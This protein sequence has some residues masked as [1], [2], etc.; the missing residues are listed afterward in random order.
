MLDFRFHKRESGGL[1]LS[2]RDKTRHLVD[3]HPVDSGRRNF[4]IRC[5]QGASAALIPASLRDLAFSLDPHNASRGR[6]PPSSSLSQPDPARRHAPQ[7]E[8]GLDDVV[9]KIRRPDRA[10]LAEWGEGLIQSPQE[11]KAVERVVAPSFLGF[12]QRPQ[13]SRLV[14]PGPVEAHQ[15]K[16]ARQSS[17]GRDAFLEELRSDLG[18]FSKILTAEFQVTSINVGALSP[19]AVQSPLQARTRVRYELV[20]TGHDF[21]HEQ[22]VGYW[23][24]AWETD[25]SGD[26][27]LQSWQAL[28]ETR[29]RS[30]SPVFVDIT[31]QALSGNSSYS[32]GCCGN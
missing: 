24:L 2:R 19:A 18:A 27:R 21:Y 10:I 4:L 25:S 3:P 17:L 22:R 29:S 31:A 20:G 11:V 6:V 13:D 14:R 12:S 23:D 26:F 30:F 32:R 28:G 9:T 5:C 1:T 7:G 16:F 15:L 8:A